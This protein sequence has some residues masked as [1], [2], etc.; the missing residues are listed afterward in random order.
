[1]VVPVSRS[2]VRL[3]WSLKSL[4]RARVSHVLD[5]LVVTERERGVVRRS[6]ALDA[7]RVPVC[8][9]DVRRQREPKNADLVCGLERAAGVRQRL[10]DIINRQGDKVRRLLNARRARC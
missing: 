2:S 8:L 9:R 4:S 10:R 3:S 1:M 6:N 7:E 5:V